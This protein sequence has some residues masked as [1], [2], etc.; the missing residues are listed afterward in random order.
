M[1]VL[2]V[3][4]KD[5]FTYNIKHYV[6]HF[7][8]DVDVIRCNTLRVDDVEKYDK[9]LFSPGPGLPNEYQILC[10][11]CQFIKRCEDKNE[12]QHCVQQQLGES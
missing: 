11:N 8:D 5:S 2:I 7:C 10:M 4:N 9:I 6:N 12:N 3:D 1:K